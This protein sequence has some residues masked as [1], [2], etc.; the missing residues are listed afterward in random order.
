MTQKAR[1]RCILFLLE[2]IVVA[3]VLGGCSKRAEQSESQTF[4]PRAED[5]PLTDFGQEIKSEAAALTL[6]AGGQFTTP[7]Q[8]KNI[9]TG[10]W[11]ASGTYPVHLSYLW[12]SDGKRLTLDTARTA[13]FSDLAPGAEQLL[14]AVI[15]TPERSG[16]YSLQFTMVQERVFWFVDKGAKSFEIPVTI[17]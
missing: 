4:V 1:K 9:G 16:K 15:T 11:P 8:V 10:V 17:Q 13:L 2:V 14:Q 5:R 3:V 6:R 12:F 7:V